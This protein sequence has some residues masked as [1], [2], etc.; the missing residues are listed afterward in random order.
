MKK[1]LKAEQIRE[2]D[3]YTIENEP[4]LSEKLME[5]AAAACCKFILE[6]KINS[7]KRFVVVCGNGN[8]GGDGVAIARMLWQN[9]NDVL[10]FLSGEEEKYSPDLKMQ[11]AK[12]GSGVDKHTYEE[13]FVFE[14]KTND[15]IIDAVF[16]TGLNRRPTGIYAEVI[17]KINELKVPIISID[18]P[19]GLYADRVPED[20]NTTIVKS[21]LLLTLAFHKKIM[22]F[23]ESENYI[24]KMFL[25][26]IGILNSYIETVETDSFVAT[27][28]QIKQLHKPRRKFGHKGTYGHSLCIGGSV[29]KFGS[30]LMSAKACLRS[31]SGLVSVFAPSNISNNYFLYSPELMFVNNNCIDFLDKLPDL[32]QYQAIGIG[33]GLG[34][35]EKTKNV[36]SKLLENKTAK[37][38]LD[39]DAINILGENR[40]MLKMLSPNMCLTPH[41]KEFERITEPARDSFHRVEIL[42]EFC[43]KHNVHVLLKGA[44]S[45][46]CT[47]DGECIFN[48]IANPGLATAGT[49]DV[50]TGV[51]T[52]LLAQGYSMKESCVIGTYV[53]GMSAD[54]AEIDKC[55]ESIIASD[56]I[57]NLGKAIKSVQRQNAF[58]QL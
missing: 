52:A 13:L 23:P 34:V 44:Y 8:N 58:E 14:P 40:E 51:I 4:I 3:R 20:D 11:I 54:L 57:D 32:S 48:T 37:I 7:E 6:K 26:D 27:I 16:G 55:K 29:G 56:I 17:N 18:L 31:G 5:R 42:K 38:V 2:G 43:R 25:I 1:I 9:G 12:L 49:G 41:F 39:A 22:F 47:P 46:T 35:N 53:H 24:K 10:V 45:I 21:D 33:M 19:S 28:E 30:V 15:I 50:L 36:L